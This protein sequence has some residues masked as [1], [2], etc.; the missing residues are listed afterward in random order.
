MRYGD[1]FLLNAYPTTNPRCCRCNVV[2]TA[3]TAM[4]HK[5]TQGLFCSPCMIAFEAELMAESIRHI[6]K[7]EPPEPGFEP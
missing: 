6:N 4:R 5:D 3:G 7:P 1:Y 2:L